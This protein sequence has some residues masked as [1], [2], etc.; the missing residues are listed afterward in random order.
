[1]TRKYP[2]SRYLGD[3]QLD[4][5]LVMSQTAGLAAV[6]AVLVSG[7]GLS[8]DVVSS[9]SLRTLETVPANAQAQGVVQMPDGTPGSSDPL[10]I[11]P[12]QRQYLDALTKEGVKPSSD[13]FALSLGSYVCQ[14]LAANQ[15]DQAVWDYVVPMV[16][17]DVRDAAT[18]GEP[19]PPVGQV[20]S[21]TA[22]YI[23][24]ATERLC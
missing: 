14:A 3:V 11:T 13:L 19:T 20:N 1:V 23:R 12:Q 2:V 15:S 10:R 5:R 6:T 9:M 7:C 18:G 21:V 22:D 17:G 24:I 16:R 4:V 8:D